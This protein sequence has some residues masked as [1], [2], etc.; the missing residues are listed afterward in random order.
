[1]IISQS[2]RDRVLRQGSQAF[3]ICSR[4]AIQ[5]C[6]YEQRSLIPTLVQHGQ[7]NRPYRIKEQGTPHLQALIWRGMVVN[8]ASL[9]SS[10]CA[11]SYRPEL[12]ICY[13]FARVDQY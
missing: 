2:E 11:L 3:L 13:N 6:Y 10:T 12:M 7:Y 1:M 5:S 8:P 4:Q 9:P